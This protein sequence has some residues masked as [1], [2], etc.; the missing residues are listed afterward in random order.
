MFEEPEPPRRRRST[1][2]TQKAPPPAMFDAE[3]TAPTEQTNTAPESAAPEPQQLAAAIAE[4]W[5]MKEFHLADAVARAE[6]SLAYATDTLKAAKANLRAFTGTGRTAVAKT[7]GAWKPVKASSN[8]G[9]IVA[10][11]GKGTTPKRIAADLGYVAKW[12][13]KEGTAYVWWQCRHV[14]LPN[15]GIE[16]EKDG[17]IFGRP[18]A[19][20]PD[21]QA[22]DSAAQ[23]TENDVLHHAA[24]V[25]DVNER[26]INLAP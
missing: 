13:E 7:P 24:T 4:V 14:L 11:L 9:K 17:E 12:G 1:T 6:Q 22:H 3:Q 10:A 16:T 2:K 25:G 8:L 26:S 21:E 5:A 23:Q 15:H 19:N 18:L 20:I